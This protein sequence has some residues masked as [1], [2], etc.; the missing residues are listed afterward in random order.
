MSLTDLKHLRER[1][2][3]AGQLVDLAYRT[4]GRIQLDMTMAESRKYGPRLNHALNLLQQAETI[5]PG[6]AEKEQGNDPRE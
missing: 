5:L 3:K 1:S 4:I 6:P 2:S